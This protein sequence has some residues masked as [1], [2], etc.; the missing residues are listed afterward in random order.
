[1]LKIH[2]KMMIYCVYKNLT[3]SLYPGALE[4]KNIYYIIVQSYYIEIRASV[5]GYLG[6]TRWEREASS[7]AS[8]PSLIGFRYPSAQDLWWKA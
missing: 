4:R 8:S 1:M 7:V 2:K 3:T 5:R 6:R